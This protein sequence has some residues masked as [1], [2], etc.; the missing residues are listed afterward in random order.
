[1]SETDIVQGEIKVMG[2]AHGSL[3]TIVRFFSPHP[4][5]TPEVGWFMK[6]FISEDEMADFVREHQLI[7]RQEGEDKCGQ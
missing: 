3:N 2:N 1:M 5:V 7:I 6:Q 4:L